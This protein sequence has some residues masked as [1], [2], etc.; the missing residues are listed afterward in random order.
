[1]HSSALLSTSTKIQPFHQLPA[2][3]LIPRR[4][5]P[6]PVRPT[7]SDLASCYYIEIRG[8]MKLTHHIFHPFQLSAREDPTEVPTKNPT[9]NP[10]KAPTISP[11]TVPTTQSPPSRQLIRPQDLPLTIRQ[12][13]LPRRQLIHPQEARR[14]HPR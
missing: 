6:L 1:M 7:V 2:L 12:S 10:S 14:H 13:L 4:G 8:F 9:A 11:N 3:I 5:A